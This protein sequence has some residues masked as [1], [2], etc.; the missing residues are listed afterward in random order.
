MFTYRYVSQEKFKAIVSWAE[1]NPDRI[2]KILETYKDLSSEWCSVFW[3]L[4]TAHSLA[5][6]IERTSC[7]YKIICDAEAKGHVIVTDN[8]LNCKLVQ[9]S[10]DKPFAERLELWLRKRFGDNSQFIK[11]FQDY[12]VYAMYVLEFAK[13]D[14]KFGFVYHPTGYNSHPPLK[15]IQIVEGA[16]RGRPSTNQKMRVECLFINDEIYP[17]NKALIK[18][19][20][21]QAVKNNTVPSVAIMIT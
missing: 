18:K 7:L 1:Q 19:A 2:D 20:I 14:Y 8:G 11:H 3:R 12:Y 6:A 9:L 15:L 13:A 10:R 21:L 4:A 17:E 16:K 5:E